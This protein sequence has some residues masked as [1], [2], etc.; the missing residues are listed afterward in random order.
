MYSCSGHCRRFYFSD[1]G[2]GVALPYTVVGIA[3]LLVAA[4]FTRVRL[5]EINAPSD[6]A[7]EKDNNDNEG[8]AATIRRLWSRRRFRLG[9]M[10]LFCYEIAEISIN[11]LFINYATSDGWMDKTEAAAL[12]LVRSPRPVLC[13][14]A[15]AGSWIMSRIPP[16]KYCFGV[17]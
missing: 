16:K 6:S 4:L 8:L 1:E 7:D 2:N 15:L 9:V 14:H 13:S 12:S 5:P 3:V 11:S 10:A 17:R